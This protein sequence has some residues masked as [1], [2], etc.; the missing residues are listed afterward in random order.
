MSGGTWPTSQNVEQE[1]AQLI[2]DKQEYQPGDVA[3]I[4]V[5]APFAPAEG[6]LTLRRNGVIY[7]ERFSM[8]EG[9]TTLRIPIEEAHIP[10][11][12]V[13]V[14]LVGAAARL[15]ADGEADTTLPSRPAYAMGSLNLSV[16]PLSRTLDVT[17][18]PAAGK[19]EPG[20]QTTVD[21]TVVDAAGKPVSD[22]EV[23]VVVV[24]E[25]ILA[26]T[27]FDWTNPVQTF[28]S[29]RGPDTGDYHLR[30]SILL[31]DPDSLL[32]NAGT[33]AQSAN[34][35]GMAFGAAESAAMPMASAPME[36]AAMDMAFDGEAKS[37][38]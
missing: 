7:T 21:L 15:N 32:E 31:V 26:L 24:D 14:D 30:G 1:E 4:L 9:S 25:A 29:E 16:P 27:G 3:E 33:V 28:Y 6:L 19:L 36:E 34:R 18:E 20:G 23:A 10:N 17:A 13:Q 5:Q 2:P 12:Y 35:D 38:R 8:P 11:V 22:A 37:R